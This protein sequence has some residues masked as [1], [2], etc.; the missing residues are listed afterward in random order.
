MRKLLLIISCFIATQG[1]A[2]KTYIH[3]GT[4]IDGVANTARN[5]MTIVVDG[6]KIT[7]IKSGYVQGTGSDN[8]I[9]L[10]DKTVLPG[11]ID[12]HVHLEFELGKNTFADGFRETDADVAYKAAVYARRTLM[13]GFTTVRDLG[14]TGVNISLRNA[15]NKGLT[16]GPYMLTAGKAISASGGHMDPS[17]GLRDD[18]MR[19]T[20]GPEDGV[21]D[22]VEECA[23]AVR[24]QHKAGADLIKIASTGGV[25]DL[26]HD[27]TGAMY[28]IEEIKAITATAHDYGMRVACHA[29][30]A[31]G[32]RRAILG[33]VNSI[34]HGTFMDAEGMALAKRYG[35]W[36]CPTLTAG[37]AVAD[38]SKVPGFFAPVVAGKAAQVGPQIQKTF[39]KAHRAGVKV[40]LG[41]DAGVYPHGKNYIEFELMVQGGM[42][43]MQAI[44]AGTI[45][46]ATLLDIQED[47][48]TLQPG[49]IADIVATTGNPLTDI[50]AVEHVTFVM[51]EGKVYKQ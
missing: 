9:D 38:S 8:V 30:G 31:E 21:A 1:T 48:G 39:A 26:G 46:A 36:Y 34:E 23:K 27:G 33:G 43:P 14:G 7:A 20:P 2:Q 35:T 13:A 29:H 28:S 4:L 40:A 17:V 25:L 32:I 10:K 3:C 12:C 47:R 22:G 37:K 18:A 24:Y 51:K 16:D 5:N 6:K 42:T 11:F 49:K 45:N 19:H 15:I 50:A 41:T 44:K